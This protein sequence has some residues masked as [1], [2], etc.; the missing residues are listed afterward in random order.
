MGSS[1]RLLKL[2]T[3]RAEQL[4]TL[5][6][7]RGTT[8]SGL[9]GAIIDHAVSSG[10]LIDETP[11]VR[12]QEYGVR[13]LVVSI[14]GKEMPMFSDDAADFYRFLESVSKVMKRARC[15]VRGA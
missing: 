9:I 14:D 7:A 11:G 15:V 6:I 13:G 5:A 12:F 10:E 3:A 4:K 1:F 8:M 2:P